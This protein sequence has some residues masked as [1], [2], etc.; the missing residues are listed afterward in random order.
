MKSIMKLSGLTDK[1]ALW[2][3]FFFFFSAGLEYLPRSWKPAVV[4]LLSARRK[5]KLTSP[6]LLEHEG[7]PEAT[8]RGAVDLQAAFQIC[9]VGGWVDQTPFLALSL[10]SKSGIARDWH[11]QQL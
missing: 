10:F 2:G 9:S 1:R 11:I 3:V 6:P 7:V 4:P 8:I 5:Q